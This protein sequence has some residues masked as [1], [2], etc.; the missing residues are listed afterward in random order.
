MLSAFRVA[1]WCQSV[2]VGLQTDEIS[3]QRV[4]T[5][6]SRRGVA[7]PASSITETFQSFFEEQEKSPGEEED[8]DPPPKKK[9]KDDD[10][11]P[12]KKEDDP[13]DPKK[14]N[15]PDQQHPKHD[16][17]ADDATV[18]FTH[19]EAMQHEKGF[20]DKST[21]LALWS[22]GDCIHVCYSVDGACPG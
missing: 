19:Q 7:R 3:Q 15:D 14:K 11:P 12:K 8:D 5:P 9:K 13:A 17:Q 18:M 4:E 2:A 16:R 6:T 21:L 20:D 1:F 22:V 10:P